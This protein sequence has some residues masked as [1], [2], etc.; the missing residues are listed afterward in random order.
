MALVSCILEASAIECWAM[1]SN[2]GRS[3][4]EERSDEG[5]KSMRSDEWQRGTIGRKEA[6]RLNAM[7]RSCLVGGRE[8]SRGPKRSVSRQHELALQHC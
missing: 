5:R 2:L 6:L 1:A 4:R 8:A 7:W 3:G